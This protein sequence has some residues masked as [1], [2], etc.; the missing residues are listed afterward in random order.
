ME[1]LPEQTSKDMLGATDRLKL[2]AP[3]ARSQRINWQSYFQ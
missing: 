3:Q 1:R 2:E